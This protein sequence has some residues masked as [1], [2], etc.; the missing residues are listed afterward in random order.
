MKKSVKQK[1]QS[2]PA[3]NINLKPFAD[4]LQG[5]PELQRELEKISGQPHPIDTN[6][7]LDTILVG[8]ARAYMDLSQ[9]M[10]LT[11]NCHHNLPKKDEVLDVRNK[12]GE[13]LYQK[14]SRDTATAKPD[15]K[16]QFY[17][18]LQEE[19]QV[20]FKMTPNLKRITLTAFTSAYWVE[21]TTILVTIAMVGTLNFSSVF[22][23]KEG[24]DIISSQLRVHHKIVN[25]EPIL[26]YFGTVWLFGVLSAILMNWVYILMIRMAMRFFSGYTALIFEKLLRVGMTNPFEHGEG[27]IINYIQ[28]DLMALDTG[29]A[30]IKGLLCSLINIP[31]ALALGCYLFGVYFMVII[32]GILILCYINA[33]IL[34]RIVPIYNRWTQ[35]TDSRLQLLK[36]VLNNIKFIKI[37]ALENTFFMKLVQKRKEE[38]IQRVYFLNFFGFLEFVIAMGTALIIMAFLLTYFMAGSSFTVGDATALLQIIDLIKV[39]LFAIPGGL[40]RMASV[41]L[42]S[43]RIDLFLKAR[44]LDAPLVYAK[45][46]PSSPYALEIRNGFF[47]WDKKLSA[48]EAHELR[49]KKI[50]SKEKRKGGKRGKDANISV[51]SESRVSNLRQTLLTAKSDQSGVT[52]NWES[53]ERSFVIENLNFKAE[54]GKLTVIIGKIGSGK[55]SILNALMGEMRVSDPKRTSIHV[56]GTVS[57]QGQN[58]WLINGTIKD[59]VL[60]NKPYDEKKF[61]WALKYSALELDLKTWDLREMHEVGESGTALSGGQRARISLAR[62]LYQE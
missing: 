19:E 33:L 28:N 31:L 56:N 9:K 36:N 24:L 52:E 17:T 1:K 40:S 41:V 58:P 51:S 53:T 38:L 12:L 27:S 25:K 62:C 55:S 32:S 18:E 45:S 16:D 6:C 23:T 49:E 11:Q 26:F 7:W 47:Y 44:E 59:N 14:H 60:L 21:M 5:Y 22:A 48:E 42:S 61:N 57:Y 43:K 8:Y 3:R 46:D 4:K 37:G 2:R 34:R 13:Q 20:N 54:R 10:I 15:Q 50:N 29:F 39:C 35:K 30:Y